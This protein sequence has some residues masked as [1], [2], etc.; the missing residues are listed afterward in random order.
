MALISSEFDQLLIR[1]A[2]ALQEVDTRVVV[3][4]G[5]TS[6]LYR[7]TK[8]AEPI[9]PKPLFTFDADLAVPNNQFSSKTSLNSALVHNGLR[10]IPG[11]RPSNKYRLSPEAKECVEIICPTTS[12]PKQQRHHRPCLFSV[13]PDTIAEALDYVDLLMTLPWEIDLADVP[14][15]NINNKMP[16][17]I[18]NPVAYVLQKTLIHDRRGSTAKRRKDAYYIYEICLLFRNAYPALSKQAIAMRN[19][20]V[21]KWWQDGV[22]KFGKLFSH[23]QSMGILDAFTMAEAHGLEVNQEIITRTIKPF[24]SMLA[25][26]G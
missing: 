12:L 20:M 9:T 3:I 6:A 5:C 1:V 15:L 25:K 26:I 22:S 7:Y 24:Y 2:Q 16:L 23:N 21:P 4:G 13:Q 14:H 19:S 18:P 11:D 17:V 8:L 10:S